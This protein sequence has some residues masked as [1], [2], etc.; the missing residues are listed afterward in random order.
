MQRPSAP[1]NWPWAFIA[2]LLVLAFFL[3]RL[4]DQAPA[5]NPQHTLFQRTIDDAARTTTADISQALWAIEPGSSQLV[6]R[7]DPRGPMLKVA[8]WMSLSIFEAVFQPLIEAGGEG[9]APTDRPRMWV[10]LVPQVRRFCRGLTEQFGGP[11]RYDPS[12]RLKQYLGLNPDRPY[13]RFVELWV[14]PGDL[15]RP[16]ADPETGDHACSLTSPTPPPRV[17]GVDD[18]PGFLRSLQ[19]ELYQ[20][21][22]APWTRLGYTY[23][24]VR[25]VRNVGASEFLVAP[26]APY[27]I[28]ASYTTE[29]YCASEPPRLKAGPTIR[30]IPHRFDPGG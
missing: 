8:A 17:R 3:G 21:N 4:F 10:T 15:F 30:L 24:W 22:G 1:R 12:F 5:L 6:W 2:L 18:F 13:A 27:R 11:E 28:D 23:D 16:C 20:P 9:I 29:A 7:D 25:G 26:G 19:Q 14:S